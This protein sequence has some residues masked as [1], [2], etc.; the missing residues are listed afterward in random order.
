MTECKTGSI[1]GWVSMG[2][3]KAEDRVKDGEYGH[4][5]LYTCMKI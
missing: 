1:R 3:G 5:A 4:N 2:G